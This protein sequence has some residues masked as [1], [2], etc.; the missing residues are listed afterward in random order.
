MDNRISDLKAMVAHHPLV[1]EMAGEVPLGAAVLED[2]EARGATDDVWVPL[3][4]GKPR[5]WPEL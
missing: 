2:V 1:A 5:P 4:G 3:S